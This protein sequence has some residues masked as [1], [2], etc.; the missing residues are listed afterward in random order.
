MSAELEA[1]MLQGE[2]PTPPRA[3]SQLHGSTPCKHMHACAAGSLQS[4]VLL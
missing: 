3:G 4:R 2:C 1:C